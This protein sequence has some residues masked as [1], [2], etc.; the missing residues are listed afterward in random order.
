MRE[1]LI[2]FLY[3]YKHTFIIVSNLYLKQDN[4]IGEK[5]VC[6]K[7]EYAGMYF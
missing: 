6:Y 4:G 7:R 2:F 3:V 1:L 5:D